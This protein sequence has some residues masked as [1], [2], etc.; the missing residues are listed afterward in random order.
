MTSYSTLIKAMCLSFIVF[1]IQPD[2]CRKSPIL[3]YP[4]AF[5]APVGGDS[6]RISQRSLAPEIQSHWAIV[7]CCLC[8]RTFIRFCRTP[9][10]DGRTNR[11]TDKRTQAH[12]QCRILVRTF[13]CLSPKLA[14][15]IPRFFPSRRPSVCLSVR[16]RST[17]R[18]IR[19]DPY[20][21]KSLNLSVKI[22]AK[23]LCY[24]SYCSKLKL[25]NIVNQKKC[26]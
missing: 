3:T 9:T 17:Y 19:N 11:W 26:I 7:W 6:G 18:K 10:C 15:K 24:Q 14:Y 1:E 16:I 2:I 20:P 8:D 21:V 5:G 25:G 23:V 13:P 22:A 4:L 12:G